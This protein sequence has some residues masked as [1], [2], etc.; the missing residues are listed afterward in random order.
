[1]QQCL[2]LSTI[3]VTLCNQKIYYSIQKN[4]PL[5]PLPSQINAVQ[6]LASFSVDPFHSY[7][8]LGAWVSHVISSLQVLWLNSVYIYILY[9]VR[10]TWSLLITNCTVNP[11]RTPFGLAIPLLQSSITRNYNHSQLF[12]TLLHMYPGY[13]HKRSRLQSLIPLLH[14]YTVYVHYALVFTALLH[15]N[16]PNS[17]NT[18]S[19]A[20]FSANS[21]YHWLSHTL[22]L[23]TSRGCLLSR[24]HSSSCSLSTELLRHFGSAYKILNRTS[25]QRSLLCVA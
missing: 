7:L 12:L 5:D 16:S 15:I 24:P 11:L 14:V 18:S 21:H 20:E 23:H 8:R 6:F 4:E 19:L 2:R 9:Y 25:E 13:N 1:M 3:A 17:L 22:H 10:V